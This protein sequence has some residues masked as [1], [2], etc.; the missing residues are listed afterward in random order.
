MDFLGFN[1]VRRGTA[2]MAYRSTLDVTRRDDVEWWHDQTA[3]GHCF[4]ADNPY[5]LKSMIV[6][7]ALSREMPPGSDQ[8]RLRQIELEFD[9]LFR[10]QAELEGQLTDLK[11][12]IAHGLEPLDVL[13]AQQAA[14]KTHLSEFKQVVARGLAPLDHLFLRQAEMEG[15]LREFQQDVARGLA[16]VAPIQASQ[17]QLDRELARCRN[18]LNEFQIQLRVARRRLRKLSKNRIIRALRWLDVCL[19]WRRG[20]TA[21]VSPGGVF[22]QVVKPQTLGQI[23]VRPESDRFADGLAEK[24]LLPCPNRSVI[25]LAD[26]RMPTA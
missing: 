3:E 7:D 9:R 10:R 11:Q 15:D 20:R 5:D 2:F 8:P 26:R 21:A 23:E 19:P 25:S 14:M 24:S 12:V 17:A 18:Q 22:S 1:I 6:R 16:P 4:V 13:S